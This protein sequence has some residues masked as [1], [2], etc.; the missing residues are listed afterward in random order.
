MKSSLKQINTQISIFNKNINT[1]Y[2]S[3][4]FN[5]KVNSVGDMKYLPAAHKEWRNNIYSY[6]QNFIKN[7]PIYDLNINELIRG[8]FN[9]YLSSKI[10]KNKYISRK[11]RRKSF[12]KI[13]ISRPE[14]KH[15]NSKVIIT[16][17]AYNR[18]K[19]ALQKK[20]RI[21]KQ[22]AYI[23]KKSLGLW[24]VNKSSFINKL[25]ATLIKRN[26]NNNTILNIYN[27]I[28]KFK[29]YKELM[30]MRKYKLKLNLNSYKFKDIFLNILGKF[31][32]KFYNKK[33]EFNI[34]KLRSI[35]YNSDILTEILK[36]KL[37]RRNLNVLR[38]IAYIIAK[39]RLS[40][41]NRVNKGNLTKSVNFDLLENKYKNLNLNFIM[42]RNNLDE[43]LN[44]IYTNLSFK[45]DNINESY[46]DIKNIIFNSINYKNIRGIRLE[47][48]GRLTKRYRADRALYKI[49]WKGGLKNIDSYKGLSSV[50]FRGHKN[51]NV[52]YTM[53]ASKRRIGSFAV[54][55]W[56]SGK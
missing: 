33:V 38:P 14:I 27:Q 24:V 12:N 15:T 11:N 8:Y 31:I 16:L 56:I 39:A 26:L 52:E 43:L 29:L 34:I 51:S 37:K 40:R 20:A 46:S 7:L 3:I 1:T 9:M 36:L 35:A 50:K 53:Q 55:G 4:P 18:E 42:K 23:F 32:S 21:L 6:N 44:N 5:T 49:R 22:K 13:F 28:I 54:K 48:K 17:Y 45:L 2:K 30:L 19:F 47:V 10:L 25:F 41:I